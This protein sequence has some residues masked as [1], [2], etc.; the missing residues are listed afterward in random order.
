[1]I[2]DIGEQITNL[3]EEVEGI[4]EDIWANCEDEF[5]LDALISK[6]QDLRENSK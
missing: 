2:N 4:V 1:M 3:R 6:L 5:R